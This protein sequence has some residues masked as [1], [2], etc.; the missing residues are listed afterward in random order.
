MD[1][2]MPQNQT[3][4]P[5]NEEIILGVDYMPILWP[6]YKKAAGEGTYLYMANHIE[7]A[8]QVFS[9]G[10]YPVRAVVVQG[11][12]QWNNTPLCDV[13]NTFA[14]CVWLLQRD[15]RGP[16]VIVSTSPASVDGLKRLS[17][18]IEVMDKWEFFR[19]G[20]K[21]LNSSYERSARTLIEEHLNGELAV[22]S[23]ESLKRLDALVASFSDCDTAVLH[24]LVQTR[25]GTPQENT[26]DPW[27][28]Q[29]RWLVTLAVRELFFDHPNKL[30]SMRE[31]LE[32]TI[33]GV[34]RTV[35]LSSTKP[36]ERTNA[37]L[38]QILEVEPYWRWFTRPDS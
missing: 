12:S 18:Q 11:N 30:A 10:T 38:L 9:D 27:F 32:S 35:E 34:P 23:A 29:Y 3:A 7:E 33:S 22:H 31:L 17:P 4:Q 26:I 13:T 6:Y 15:F 8:M 36:R 14:F 28:D 5:E 24:A 37:R 16:I 1:T 19:N 2:T 25:V 21:Q 20:S